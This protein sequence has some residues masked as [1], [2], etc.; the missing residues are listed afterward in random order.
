M[1]PLLPVCLPLFVSWLATAPEPC[2]HSQRGHENKDRTRRPNLRA[3]VLWRVVLLA[4]L[5]IVGLVTIAAA[6][7]DSSSLSGLVSDPSG[8]A[9]VGAKVGLR[10]LATG[11]RREALTDAEG[12]Y[13][14]T[15]LAPGSYE[16]T[17]EAT[18]FKQYHDA[19]VSLQVAQAEQLNLQM[20]IG[21][22]TE[23]V[24]VEGSVS[25]I[26]TQ[27]AAL[28][29]VV[30]QEKIASLPLNGRQFLQ[31]ALLV[32][33]ANGGGRAVQQN[34]V[35]QG[36]AGGLS[37]SGGRTN[38]TAFLLDGAANLDPDYNSLNYS[39]SIDAIAE[40]QVQTA[41]YSAEYG[42]ASG[43][44]INVV[45][46]SGSNDLHGS[47]WEFLRNNKLD[48]RPFNLVSGDTPK[49]QRNQF[50]ATLGAPVVKNRLFTFLAY[51]GLRVRQA[52]AN[53]TTVTV[54][55]QLERQGDFSQTPGGIY[56]PRTLQNGVRQQFLNNR[57]PTD[58]L[59][60]QALAAVRALPLPNVGASGYVN[61]SGILRQDNNN[62]SGRLDFITK[63]SFTLFGRYSLSNEKALI[64]DVVPG[65]DNLN[66][67]RSQN[68][69]L[70]STA[71]LS[72]RLINEARFGFS[73]L[74]ILNGLPE[75]TF[76][77]A[78]TPVAIPR[79]IVAGF[80]TMGGGGSFTGTTGGGIVLVRNN[81]FQLYDNLWL[82]ANCCKRPQ[83]V[84][85]TNPAF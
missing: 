33:G 75:L 26:N 68:A 63:Q 31:L 38:N 21:E 70:S 83:N 23:M 36:Q 81:T 34:T 76:D 73:R 55:T 7:S 80:P 12:R 57:I 30:G 50:G 2:A 48:A 42:R 10:N 41:A 82:F 84:V 3:G 6:Q 43:G 60:P 46:K 35:R 29:A 25:L 79:F 49:Y 11:T 40:F 54:P 62:Y 39:P 44:Q 64:P 16:I 15:L 77:V 28:G 8:A 47:A 13:S 69:V 51:E 59:N 37:V 67:A 85:V 19:R 65:C 20:A 4:W 22:A 72:S 18:G 66:N 74:R 61:A 14:F 27:T 24:V 71:V 5:A 58:R 32:P 45:T 52:A 78:G 1:M 56:D 9:V 53:L 17:V